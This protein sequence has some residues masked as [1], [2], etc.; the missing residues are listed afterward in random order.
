V[1]QDQPM[2]GRKRLKV[3][4]PKTVGELL[5]GWQLHVSRRREIHETAAR[6]AQGWSY[7]IG[8]PTAVL[9]ALAGSSAVAAWQSEGSNA[10]L[11][12]VGGALGIVA[13]ILVSVQTFLDLGA[14]AEKHRQAAVSYK[15]LLRQFERIPPSHEKLPDI[16]DKSE[17]ARALQELE[18]ELAE[19]DSVAPVVPRRM[20]AR[21]EAR[22]MEVVSARELGQ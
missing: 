8:V 22:P 15:R 19:V 16:G 18:A 12:V 1:A 2:P 4:E 21:V 3:F 20:A 13:A 11:A 5:I 14:R 9:A 10:T 6:R 17:L 7:A